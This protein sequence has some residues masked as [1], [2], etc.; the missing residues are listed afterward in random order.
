MSF[1]QRLKKEIVD[2]VLATIYFALWIGV[3]MVIKV[4]ILAEYQIEFTRN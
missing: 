1:P 4:L 3:L 2:V